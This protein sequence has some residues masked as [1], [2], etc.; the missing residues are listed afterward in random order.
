MSLLMLLAGCGPQQ[1]PQGQ[2]K[3]T[4]A[5][6]PLRKGDGPF[7]LSLQ[8]AISDLDVDRPES[9]PGKGL[10]VL[11]SVP[12]PSPDFDNYAVVAFDG[13]GICEIRASGEVDNSDSAGSSTMAKID[14]IA[15]SLETKY[16]PPTKRDTC[17]G[18]DVSCQQ[19]FFAMSVMNGERLYAY[20]WNKAVP[21]IREIIAGIVSTDL[22]GLIPRLEYQTGDAKACKA[23]AAKAGAA[24]L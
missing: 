13:V 7:G 20:Q 24:N 2:Q 18:G 21:P 9:Q 4:A 1:Q 6:T 14:R 17:I 10:Y 19:Q 16:G 12:S 8:S 3:D 22:A 11:R 23:A 15:E 5:A